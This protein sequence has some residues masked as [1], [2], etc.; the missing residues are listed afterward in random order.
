MTLLR[1]FTVLATIATLAGCAAP[2]LTSS[3]RLSPA[4]AVSGNEIVS[5]KQNRVTVRAETSLFAP[6]LD[7]LP[8]FTVTITNR[9]NAPLVFSSGNVTA[10]SGAAPV[11]IY[12]PDD[13]ESAIAHEA[14][15]DKFTAEARGKTQ[16]ELATAANGLPGGPP[17]VTANANMA[18]DVAQAGWAER[19][20]RAEL[21][22][23]LI[24]STVP[25]GGSVGGLIKLYPQDIVPGA[26][27]KLVVALPGET[28]EFTFN[29][30]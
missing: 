16:V 27:L 4:T 11:R 14:S 1:L 12:S 7:Q 17:L 19:R 5:E 10:F 20:R 3:H 23:M 2:R 6:S 15:F 8:T 9:G 29:V 18:R 25:P 30:E 22:Q 13:L 26:P 24:P 21:A 28:H